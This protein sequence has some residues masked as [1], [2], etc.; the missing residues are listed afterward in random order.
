VTLCRPPRQL[1][2]AGVFLDA[3]LLNAA[4]QGL[5]LLSLLARRSVCQKLRLTEKCAHWKSKLALI[6]KLGSQALAAFGAPSIDHSAAAARF[7]AH[8][9][10]M[11][12]GAACFGRLVSA[13][14]G[15]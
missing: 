12:T 3:A 1:E 4:L 5:A 6:E 2:I 11:G 7:H 15:N 13:F 10:A 14:H 9:K 8:H